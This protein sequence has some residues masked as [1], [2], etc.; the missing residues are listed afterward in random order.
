M[1][2]A[3]LSSFGIGRPAVFVFFMLSGYWVMRAFAA[4]PRRPG[5]VRRF[6][7]SR[8]L[9]VWPA[10]AAAFLAAFALYQVLPPRGA[11]VGPG[12][13]AGLAIAAAVLPLYVLVELPLERRRPAIVGRLM[14]E[15]GVSGPIGGRHREVWGAR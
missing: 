4:D 8:A 6:Y 12:F 9:R 5:A 15:A 10:F 2:G 11:E 14:G 1:V 7:L 13:L 3:H